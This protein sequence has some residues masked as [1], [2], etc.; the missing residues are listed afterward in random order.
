MHRSSPRAD[1]A[2]PYPA[3][4]VCAPGQL[5]H[6]PNEPV[7][8]HLALFPASA[9]PASARSAASAPPWAW[10]PLREPAPQ[11]RARCSCETPGLLPRPLP[12]GVPSSG[13]LAQQ[14][15]G[16]F[17]RQLAGA[18]RSGLPAGEAG[19]PIERDFAH[20]RFLWRNTCRRCI[21]CCGQKRSA[22]KEDEA[23]EWSVQTIPSGERPRLWV[24]TSVTGKIRRVLPAP[25]AQV[26]ARSAAQPWLARLLFRLFR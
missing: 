25:A 5:E 3:G 20:S 9:R 18:F 7:P 2:R 17:A 26:P 10:S 22:L 1:E 6:N 13:H 24:R 21:V 4:S 11:A 19:S 12:M 14:R 16:W 8:F 15:M 23:A